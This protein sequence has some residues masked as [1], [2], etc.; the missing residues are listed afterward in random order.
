MSLS[1]GESTGLEEV[2]GDSLIDLASGREKIANKLRTFPGPETIGKPEHETVR[3]LLTAEVERRSLHT[4][5]E[6]KPSK[7]QWTAF[8]NKSF[9]PDGL[10]FNVF[11]PYQKESVRKFRSVIFRGIELDAERYEAEV[12]LGAKPEDLPQVQHRA[13]KL[14]KEINAVKEAYEAGKAAE[15]EKAVRVRSENEHVEVSLGLRNG[16]A[17]TPSPANAPTAAVNPASLLGRQPGE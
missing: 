2:G 16:R 17:A 10:L 8:Y 7:E 5:N 15:K 6:K 9:A 14:N 3:D 4:V 13:F 1:C 11:R 12:E